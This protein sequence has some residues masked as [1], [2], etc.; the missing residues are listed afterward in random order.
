ML[1]YVTT[2]PGKLHEARAYL[3]DDTV[4]G[5]DYDYTEIQ[6]ESLETIAAEGAREA[7]REVGGP[8]IVDDSGLFINAFDGF[9]G[10]YSSYVESKLGIENVWELGKTVDDR[11]ASFRCI[12]AYCDGEP[13]AASPDP[14]DRDDR[15][16]AAAAG[17]GERYQDDEP[18]PVKL[19]VGSVRGTLV[20]PRG[21]GGFGYDP[22]FEHDGSTFAERSSEEKNALSHR[23]RALAKFAD[24][25]DQ[26]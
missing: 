6:S 8:V 4:D 17:A 23:G 25:F 15:A 9:P 13:V 14:V 19:F 12:L 18:L 1:H 11:A 21:D 22:I 10:P 2:N 26:R 20:A 3:G 5:Y 24:W 7:Y 16:A